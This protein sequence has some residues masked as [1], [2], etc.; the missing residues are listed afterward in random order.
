[1]KTSAPQW[2]DCSTWNILHR[3]GGPAG[4]TSQVPQALRR[5]TCPRVLI[6]SRRSA[7]DGGTR[8]LSFER[9]SLT[10]RWL[11]DLCDVPRGTPSPGAPARQFPGR[12][13]LRGRL[14]HVEHC[15]KAFR[16]TSRQTSALRLASRTSLFHLGGPLDAVL[17]PP[18]S[19]RRDHHTAFRAVPRG[20]LLPCLRT[21][22]SG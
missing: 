16:L 4:C 12:P 2:T 9:P 15:S 7:T 22:S 3:S 13:S 8:K 18:R 11:P 1:M 17:S 14:F 10:D 6:P 21:C 5:G 19:S 20:T